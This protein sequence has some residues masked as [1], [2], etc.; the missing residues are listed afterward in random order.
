MNEQNDLKMLQETIEEAEQLKNEE[1]KQD[2][3]L[4][5]SSS[6]DEMKLYWSENLQQTA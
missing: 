1:G 6:E 4:V 2:S 3:Q 5:V